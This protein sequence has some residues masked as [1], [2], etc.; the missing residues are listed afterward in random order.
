MWYVLQ[1]IIWCTV[2][3]YYVTEIAPEDA[4]GGIMLEASIITFLVTKL[5]SVCID[6]ARYRL[7]KIKQIEP[8]KPKSLGVIS[9]GRALRRSHQDTRKGDRIN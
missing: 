2:V 6:A 1:T 8:A 7:T 3:Y 5:L 4:V 9:N